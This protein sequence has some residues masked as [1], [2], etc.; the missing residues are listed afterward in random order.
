MAGLGTRR[1]GNGG[2]VG[3]DCEPRAKVLAKTYG[4]ERVRALCGGLYKVA[5]LPWSYG[6]EQEQQPPPAGACASC[7]AKEC[8]LAFAFVLGKLI[9]VRVPFASDMRCSRGRSKMSLQGSVASVCVLC[10]I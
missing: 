10:L 8:A 7:I 2:E 3:D 5:R 4:S 6:A 9:G 1:E